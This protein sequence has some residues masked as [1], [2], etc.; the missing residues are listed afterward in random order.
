MGILG[1]WCLIKAEGRR[2]AE[3][4]RLCETLKADLEL[5]R[6]AIGVDSVVVQDMDTL[7]QGD[8]RLQDL[9]KSKPTV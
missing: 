2:S 8:N 7:L 9:R 3:F 6:V 5:L 1:C 4:N